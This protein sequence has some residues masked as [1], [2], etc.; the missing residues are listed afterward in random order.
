M[1]DQP[2]VGC[3][4]GQTS[5]QSII[6][7]AMTPE[8][9]TNGS[10]YFRNRCSN[11]RRLADCSYGRVRLLMASVDALLLQGATAFSGSEET[12][13]RSFSSERC[14]NKWITIGREEVVNLVK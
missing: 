11:D 8:V 3:M 10:N 9:G 12:S 6:I 14:V 5:A 2:A 7:S 1:D 4:L 13:R